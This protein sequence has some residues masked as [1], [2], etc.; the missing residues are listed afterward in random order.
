MARKHLHV[1]KHPSGWQV[2]KQGGEQG[3]ISPQDQERRCW[4]GESTSSQ[5]QTLPGDHP[6]EGWPLP[7]R[8]Y[9]RTRSIPTTRLAPISGARLLWPCPASPGRTAARTMLA[10][11]D[12]FRSLC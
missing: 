3:L 7:V 6:R 2:K 10:R 12:V 1:T 5:I 8:T 4:I 9:L 11:F